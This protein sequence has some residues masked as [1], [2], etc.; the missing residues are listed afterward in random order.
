MNHIPYCMSRVPNDTKEEDDITEFN[1]YDKSDMEL[2]AT[3][4][5]CYIATVTECC[6][7]TVGKCNED[8]QAVIIP[9]VVQAEAK[10]QEY[11]ALKNTVEEG[12]PE[13]LEECSLLIQ[14]FHK[15]GQV[16]G[17]RTGP[18]DSHQVKAL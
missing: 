18:A 16:L 17:G 10:D 6:V 12:F 8:D 7:S 2:G 13:K 1:E 15:C 4:S 11:L 3:I 5:K 9:E 14:P